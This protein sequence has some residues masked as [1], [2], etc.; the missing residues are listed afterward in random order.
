VSASAAPSEWSASVGTDR[1]TLPPDILFGTTDHYKPCR[2][3]R[4]HCYDRCCRPISH[5]GRHYA[6]DGQHIVAVWR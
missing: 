3:R 6:A 1:R 5:T 2:D 4:L